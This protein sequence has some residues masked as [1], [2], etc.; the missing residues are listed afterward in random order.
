MSRAQGT[1]NACMRVLVDLQSPPKGPPFPLSHTVL[2]APPPLRVTTA[3]REHEKC[4]TCQG[5]TTRIHTETALPSLRTRLSVR[6]A[7]SSRRPHY[8]LAGTG[9]LPCPCCYPHICI[10]VTLVGLDD[11]TLGHD[12][13]VDTL[14]HNVS[15]TRDPQCMHARARGSPKSPKGTTVSSLP[16]S[17]A[18]T[19]P[20]SSD[21]RNAGAREVPHV[22][23]TDNSHPHRNGPPIPPHT[24][25]CAACTIISTAPSAAINLRTRARR[26]ARSS[27]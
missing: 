22:P 14:G 20:T 8:M 4:P 27:C 13:R 3:T 11:R 12:A 10:S 18:R 7:R 6:H 23:R 9:W 5:L 21:D 2:H 19:P 16:H 26:H 17:P 1:H 24:S 25:Q 15:R